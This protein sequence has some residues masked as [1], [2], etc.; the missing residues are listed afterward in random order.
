M[1]LPSAN[2]E[3]LAV[4]AVFRITSR[5]TVE[6]HRRPQSLASVAEAGMAHRPGL[7]TEDEESMA[8]APESGLSTLL[9]VQW[10]KPLVGFWVGLCFTFM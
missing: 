5:E 4:R 6:G 7:G 3:L 1:L 8:L 9:D 2:W 10:R